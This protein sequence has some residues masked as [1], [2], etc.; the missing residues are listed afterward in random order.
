MGKFDNKIQKAKSYPLEKLYGSELKKVSA[1]ILRG[2]CPFHNDSGK[3]NFTIYTEKNTWWCFVCN[4]GRD[5]ID[6]YMKKNNVEFKE[7]V[8]ALT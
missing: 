4:I 2:R 1:N 7:A 8:E 5:S 3:P 6:F